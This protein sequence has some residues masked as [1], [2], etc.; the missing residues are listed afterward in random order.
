MVTVF[1]TKTKHRLVRTAPRATTMT[2]HS[3]IPIT[4]FALDAYEDCDGNCINDADADGVCDE[5]EVAGCR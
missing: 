5:A 3:W 1:V 4:R 2:I